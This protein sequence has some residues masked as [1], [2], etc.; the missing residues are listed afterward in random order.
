MVANSLSSDVETNPGPWA[1]TGCKGPMRRSEW[2]VKCN[3][4][5]Q[6]IHWNC[7]ELGE[8]GRRSKD[9]KRPC[10][11]EGQSLRQPPKPTPLQPPGP[12]RGDKRREQRERRRTRRKYIK[13]PKWDERAKVTGNNRETVI[14][15]WNIQ[16]ARVTFPKRNRFA[17]II[18][19]IVKS[20]AEIVLFS[21]LNDERAA[22]QWIKAKQIYGALV[23]GKK[24][25]IF[26]R[27]GWTQLIGKL[28]GAG[29]RSEPGAPP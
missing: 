1:C 15:T 14:W 5:K 3:S 16:R 22:M 26:H 6:W 17:D 10:C 18:K 2:S 13:N 28:K 20:K 7:I 19:V 8:N 27:D 12:S 29:K 23:H 24:S 21:E 4:C 25:G 9:F 11:T